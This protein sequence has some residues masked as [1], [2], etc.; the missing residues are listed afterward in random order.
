MKSVMKASIKGSQG[1]IT[2]TE[3]SSQLNGSIVFKP[4]MGKYTR[5]FTFSV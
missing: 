2:G 1:Y 4:F 5:K 3:S